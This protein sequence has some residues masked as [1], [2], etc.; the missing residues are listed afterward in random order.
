MIIDAAT[1]SATG[2][3]ERLTTEQQATIATLEGQLGATRELVP[4]AAGTE[5]ALARWRPSEPGATR[6]RAP[7]A[8]GT[9]FPQPR[10]LS[11]P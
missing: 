10:S 1:A 6:A 4:A 9:E 3:L 8:A 2:P 5:F 11:G 7:A